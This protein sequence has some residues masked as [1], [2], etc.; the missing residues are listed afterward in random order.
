MQV[1]HRVEFHLFAIRHGEGVGDR[2]GAAIA[3]ADKSQADA[4]VVGGKDIAR[5]AGQ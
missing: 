3:A 2:A 1:G 5:Q 4:V